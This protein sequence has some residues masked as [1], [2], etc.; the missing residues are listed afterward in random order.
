MLRAT[1]DWGPAII[2]HFGHHHHLRWP[3]ALSCGTTTH[4]GSGLLMFVP[5]Y[6]MLEL[7]I[8]MDTTMLGVQ[9]ILYQLSYGHPEAPKST[10]VKIFPTLNQFAFG[11]FHPVYIFF[12]NEIKQP[13][14]WAKQYFGWNGNIDQHQESRCAHGLMKRWPRTKGKLA[15]K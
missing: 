4:G 15:T 11:Y 13:S 7:S 12:D 5:I 9:L 14:G 3:C 8:N 6:P 2:V 1:L 10:P